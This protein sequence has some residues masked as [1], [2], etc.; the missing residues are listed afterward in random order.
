VIEAA[1]STIDP[2]E[3]KAE[4]LLDEIHRERDRTREARGRAE[5]AQRTAQALRTEL[6]ERLEKIEDERVELM[7]RTRRQAKNDLD[8]LR[9]EIGK[10]RADL[11]RAREPLEEIQSIKQAAED[12]EEEVEQPARR[13]AVPESAPDRPLRLGDQVNVRSLQ[14]QGIVT[15]LGEAEA[16]VQIGSLRARVRFGD[17]EVLPKQ[18]DTNGKHAAEW[19]SVTVTP[20]SPGGE[21]SLRGQR[22]EDALVNLDRY[23]DAAYAAGLHSARIIHGKGTG[24]LREMVRTELKKR[25]Y[26]DRH[27]TADDR[28]GGEGVTVVY[29]KND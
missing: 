11:A 21:I 17:L 25:S 5:E 27:E 10:L 28:E 12:L 6:A 16:E 13:K 19:A 26:I 24:T 23:L 29:F 4:N 9:D 8:A 20:E 1:Q 3:I 15:A 22:Y 18:P 14:R 7:E 2:S